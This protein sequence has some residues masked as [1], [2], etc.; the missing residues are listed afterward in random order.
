MV[1]DVVCGMGVEKDDPETFSKTFNGTVFY[2]CSAECMILFS[3]DPED[4]LDLNNSKEI[5]MAK[6]L[7]CGM[8][9]DESN[10]PFTAVYKGTIYYFCS[11]S[12]KRE[13]E[14]DPEKFLKKVDKKGSSNV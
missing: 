12:C 13:F 10:P 11:N 7:V 2:F 4:Y 9:V 14:R 5:T 3:K 8:E 6:D 1:K